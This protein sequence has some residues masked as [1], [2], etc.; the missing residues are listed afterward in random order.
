[1]LGASWGIGVA[2][3]DQDAEKWRRGSAVPEQTIGRARRKTRCES[4]ERLS[5]GAGADADDEE[6]GG[7]RSREE[8]K[9]D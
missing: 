9:E 4:S 1:M 2:A 7:E 8:G 5:A 3:L 6:S